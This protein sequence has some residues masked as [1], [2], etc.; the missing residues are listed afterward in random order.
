MRER[1]A[2]VDAASLFEIFER[3]VQAPETQSPEVPALEIGLIGFR[4]LGVPARD[5]L[6]GIAADANLQMLGN[7]ARDVILNAEQIGGV[8]VVLLTP[9]LHAIGGSHQLHFD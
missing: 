8:S 6:R 9:E 2:R 3:F 1:V 7:I 4:V 5:S